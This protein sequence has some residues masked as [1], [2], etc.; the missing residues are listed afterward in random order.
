MAWEVPKYVF[1]ASAYALLGISLGLAYR[2][3]PKLRDQPSVQLAT[4]LLSIGAAL[5]VLSTSG[6]EPGR[7]HVIYHLGFQGFLFL[8][9]SLCHVPVLV[10]ISLY[11]WNRL[12]ERLT[13]PGKNEEPRRRPLNS[14]QAWRLVQSHL[15]ALA[16]APVNVYHREQLAEVY[17]RLGFVDSA[18]GEYRKAIECSERGY[19]QSRLLFK[20]SRL[21]I[22]KK[23]DI[24]AA[25]PLL[26]RLI[27]LYPRSC[28][29]AYAR[30]IINHY[31]ARQ[32]SRL[33]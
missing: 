24:P 22:D 16:K 32:G 23:G 25:L 20:S 27:R 17:L 8:A 3:Y 10:Y 26:R 21:L 4:V 5:P 14:R 28:F 30:R 33:D 13:S 2:S 18:I 1:A 19:T 11:H 15:E 7:L 12:L 9:A 31:E 6:L 29:A